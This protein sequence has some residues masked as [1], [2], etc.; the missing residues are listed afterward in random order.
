MSAVVGDALQFRRILVGLDTSP[1]SLAATGAAATL[2]ARLGAELLGLYVEDEDLIRLA[3][4]PFARIVRIPSGAHEPL[5]R[6]RVEAELRAVGARAREALAEAAAPERL[7]FTFLVARGRV[8]PQGLAA[9]ERVDLLVLGTGG[10]RRSG[11][12]GVGDTARA[13]AERARCSVL[14][15]P[16][17]GRLADPVVGVDDG[18]GGA[19]RALAVARALAGPAGAAVV[20]APPGAASAVPGALARLGPGLVVV[21]AGGAYAAGAGLEALVAA[22]AALLL[23]R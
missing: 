23:V 17:D 6:P 11:R 18:S 8:I 5:D 1:G 12:A 13:A 15:L 16:R 19:P 10:R 7:S 9:A 22:R 4:L 14:L 21:A 20:V 3:D 2:A